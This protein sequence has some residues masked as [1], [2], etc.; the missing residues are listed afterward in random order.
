MQISQ[1]DTKTKIISLK[2]SCIVISL[3][4]IIYCDIKN[5]NVYFGKSFF[6]PI[7]D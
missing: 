5:F 3:I 6:L 1:D 4:K 7:I 2:E